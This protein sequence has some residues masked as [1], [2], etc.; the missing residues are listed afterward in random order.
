GARHQAL[1]GADPQ[2]RARGT[3]GP[4]RA[5]RRELP[6]A[7][8]R[9]GEVR[10]PR[11]RHVQ[12]RGRAAAQPGAAGRARRPRGLGSAGLSRRRTEAGGVVRPAGA[13]VVGGG[14]PP[15]GAGLVGVPPVGG[16][17]V[18]GGGVVAVGGGVVCAGGGGGA[19]VAGGAGAF[20]VGS[21]GAATPPVPLP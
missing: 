20:G 11:P 7:A 5:G 4:P 10:G 2:L 8:D 1:V 16:A 21:S 6:A 15:V 14:V 18:V 3:R 17:V 9:P 12:R 19:V 13:V